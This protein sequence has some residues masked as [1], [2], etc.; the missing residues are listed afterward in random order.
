L[1]S[2]TAQEWSVPDDA[3]Y[4]YLLA[5]YLGDGT[6]NPR[7]PGSVRLPIVNDRSYPAISREILAAM[8]ITFPGAGVRV[9][10]SSAGESD[11][12]CITHP[13]VLRAFPQHGPDP[14]H[15]RVI[16]LADWQLELTRAHPG[17]LIRGLIHSDGCRTVN[18]F[19]TK[20]PSG[21]VAEYS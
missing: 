6:L 7:T 19:R 8:A 5:G 10:P 12:L 18:S 9:H 21:R 3:S 14:K 11:V 4:C 20:L 2:Q 16:A 13:A 15:D 1:R 17:T